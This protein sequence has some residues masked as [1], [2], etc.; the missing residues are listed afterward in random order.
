MGLR[1]LGVELVIGHHVSQNAVNH[2]LEY[3]I[4]AVKDA[5]VLTPD[6]LLIADRSRAQ[7][8]GELVRRIEKAGRTDLL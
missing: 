4:L 2:L 7:E 6:A 1:E 3:G 8:V 5:P